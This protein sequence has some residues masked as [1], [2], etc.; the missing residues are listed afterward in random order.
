ME[1]KFQYIEVPMIS[2]CD[3]PLSRV[4]THMEEYGGYGIGLTKNWGR[5]KKLEPVIYTTPTSELTTFVK[6]FVSSISD[7]RFQE[8]LLE[9]DSRAKINLAQ[10]ESFM[11]LLCLIKPVEGISHK[12]G[13]GRICDFIQENE[14]RHYPYSRENPVINPEHDNEYREYAYKTAQSDRLLFDASDVAFIIV[15]SE[16]DIPQF[17]DKLKNLEEFHMR[18]SLEMLFTRIISRDTI[19]Q[20]F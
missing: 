4:E 1:G 20:N 5:T 14:W 10:I 3:I 16:R 6:L 11:S 17:I 18:S 7:N 12:N 13:L 8:V 15:E 2:F 9:L 19:R